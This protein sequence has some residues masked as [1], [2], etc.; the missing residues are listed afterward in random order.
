MRRAILGG[1]IWLTGVVILQPVL[2]DRR[3]A[4]ALLLLAALCLFPLALRLVEED[5]SSEDD[6]SIKKRLRQAI[7]WLQLPAALLLAWS[8]LRDG[9]AASLTNAALALPWLFTL[10]LTALL[11]LTRLW[12]NIRMQRGSWLS[13]RSCVDLSLVYVAVGGGWAVLDRA[14]IRPLDFEPIIVLLTAVHFHYAGFLLPLTT[15]L[16]ASRSGPRL[17]GAVAVGVLAGVP[18]VAVG[19]STTQLGLSPLAEC[20]AALWLV[21][22]ASLTAWLHLQLTWDSRWSRSARLLW[23]SAGATLLASMGMAAMYGL[24]AYLPADV[25]TWLDIP[26]MQAIHGT[27]NALGFGLCAV[28]GWTLAAVRRPLGEVA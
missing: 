5:S 8:F 12:R 9:G 16:A 4:E 20:L 13:A 3:W 2:T 6:N 27:G 24:R 15:G 26:T 21:A 23:G 10:S 22:A 1:T 14:G 19:I 18:L 25:I 7:A 17:Q 28:L 11:G